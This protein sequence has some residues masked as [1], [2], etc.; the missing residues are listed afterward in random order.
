M[1][2]TENLNKWSNDMTRKTISQLEFYSILFLKQYL[3]KD[4]DCDITWFLPD[5]P[6][7]YRVNINQNNLIEQSIS[8]IKAFDCET[9]TKINNP[10]N[11]AKG[12]FNLT[13]NVHCNYAANTFYIPDEKI[14]Q[15]FLNKFRNNK[16]VELSKQLHFLSYSWAKEINLNLDNGQKSKILF[17]TK[18]NP[19]IINEIWQ[20]PDIG[21]YTV[22]TGL[23][24]K[25][26][27]DI[28]ILNIPARKK[29]LALIFQEVLSN[30][31]MI[32][33]NKVISQELTINIPSSMFG[34]NITINI[35][36]LEKQTIINKP[37]SSK[38]VNDLNAELSQC[39]VNNKQF[40]ED[41]ITTLD[42]LE[43]QH[44]DKYTG[45][46]ATLDLDLDNLITDA[47]PREII[48]LIMQA[49][50]LKIKF[51][52]LVSQC[53]KIY[54]KLDF[55]EAFNYTKGILEKASIE[56]Q[57]KKLLET[58]QKIEPKSQEHH[59]NSKATILYYNDKNKKIKV[60]NI[61]YNLDEDEYRIILMFIKK[62]PD[63]LKS[64]EIAEKLSIQK[65]TATKKVK[66]IKRKYSILAKYIM[67]STRH[68]KG[69]ELKISSHQINSY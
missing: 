16:N 49:H 2:D 30:Y 45:L 66:S 35:K 1:Q 46:R 48:S 22:F 57:S 17:Y 65:N 18:I 26:L 52:E 31:E 58:Q 27:K 53:F 25:D 41:I 12:M 56:E 11:L 68:S 28:R 67:D 19:L 20:R 3:E 60:E 54:G 23:D 40:K 21:E 39:I 69:Y 4:L 64:K 14:K 55:N 6:M 7:K 9:Y 24:A 47:T 38:I 32:L 13:Q 51:S 33:E 37:K 15:E 10:E 36:E 29:I 42:L 50:K 63:K 59:E 34:Q 62:L 61:E 5:I 44:P 43:T 8:E